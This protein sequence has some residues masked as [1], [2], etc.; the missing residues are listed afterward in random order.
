V[1][2]TLFSLFLVDDSQSVR[3]GR[4]LPAATLFENACACVC[5][6]A[7]ATQLCSRK[8]TL[9]NSPTAPPPPP[10][11]SLSLSSKLP[12]VRGH[13]RGPPG[14]G[15]LPERP[16]PRARSPCRRVRPPRATALEGFGFRAS[17]GMG[18]RVAARSSQVAVLGGHRHVWHD[19]PISCQRVARVTPG[20]FGIPRR[21]LRS[22]H[23][24]GGGCRS[25]PWPDRSGRWIKRQPPRRH[26]RNQVAARGG[27]VRAYACARA[28]RRAGETAS[29]Y[30]NVVPGGGL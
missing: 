23:R 9:K 27:H 25:S 19:A 8:F 10:P 29:V 4:P 11:R 21:T 16:C 26:A 7:P 2:H 14:T 30:G 20:I 28:C 17:W 18:T 3:R 24:S 12:R 22:Q 6:R 1:N 5:A 13:G 15:A